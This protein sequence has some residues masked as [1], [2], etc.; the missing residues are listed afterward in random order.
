[1]ESS[2]ETTRNR[3]IVESENQDKY[4]NEINTIFYRAKI[5]EYL[6]CWSSDNQH[7][8]V[9][10]FWP[11]LTS[12]VSFG[13][14]NSPALPRPAAFARALYNDSTPRAVAIHYLTPVTN[15]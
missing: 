5:A 10:L 4:E 1:M 6:L 14:I 8:V 2:T 12:F 11:K 3:K 7:D 13:S 15:T 9:G